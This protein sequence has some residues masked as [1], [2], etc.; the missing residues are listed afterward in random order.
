MKKEDKIYVAG[1]TGMVG[2]AIVRRL[3]KDGYN[4]LLV[5]SSKDLDLKDSIQVDEFYRFNQP[6]YVFLAAA[7]V[8]GIHSNNIYR[9][10]F[11]YDNLMIQ[12]NIIHNAYKYNVKKLLFLGSSCIY[13]RDCPQ[14]IKEEYL[15]T[16]PL[17]QTNEPYALAKIAGLK[18]CENYKRQY[19]CNFISAMPTNIFGPNDNY[20]LENSHV[21]AAF[22]RK[23]LEAK[24]NH[25]PEVP[26]W[27][28]GKPKREFLHADDL[29]DASLFLMQNYDGLKWVNVG[30]GKDI[31]IAE[32][33]EIMADAIDYKGVLKYDSSK[34]DGTIL[35]RLDTSFINSLGWSPKISLKEGIKAT[36]DHVIKNGFER[37]KPVIN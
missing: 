3:Q 30:T 8:G 2:S 26:I 35:K 27:G 16:G 12:N 33:A 25:D 1:H 14:P 4:N 28:S 6:D 37:I 15:L 29:A 7:K 32:L 21:F 13:P 10:E 19:G 20:D 11:I 34:P 36:F 24:Q 17:E 31:S 18:M 5:A 23:F 9:A 22:I